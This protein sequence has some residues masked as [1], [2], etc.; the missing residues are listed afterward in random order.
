MS[1][2][3]SRFLCTPDRH[4]GSISTLNSKEPRLNATFKSELC[5]TAGVPMTFLRLAASQCIFSLSQ[6]L[7]EKALPCSTSANDKKF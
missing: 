1:G 7:F 2:S 3:N 5:Q 4:S 6:L